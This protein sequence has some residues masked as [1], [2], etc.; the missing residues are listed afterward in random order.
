MTKVDVDLGKIGVVTEYRDKD[1]I[2]SIPGSSWDATSRMWHVPLSWASCKI[3]RGVFGDRLEIG[4]ELQV[5]AWNELNTRINPSLALRLQT[6]GPGDKR[7]LPFQRPGVDFLVVARHA[8]LADEMGTG[9]TIQTIMALHKLDQLGENPFPAC[10]IVPNAVKVNWQR[11]FAKWFPDVKTFVVGGSAAKRMAT[12]KEAG[13]AI[14]NG[15]KVVVILAWEI[16]WR[17]SRLAPYG[18]VRLSDP[19]RQPKELNRI[20]WRTVVADEAH[21]MKDP[22]A[23]QTRATWQIG[24]TESCQFRFALTGTPIANDPGDLW[25]LMHF[26]DPLEYPS[27]TKW[28]DRFCLLSWNAFGGMEV[29]GVR[30]DTREEF[31]SIVDPRMRRMP[32]E[33]VLP[34][35]PKK[36]RS[37][38]F[39]EMSSK[40]AKAYR[41]IEASMVAAVDSAPLEDEAEAVMQAL[42][43]WGAPQRQA[44]VI[45]S[46]PLVRNL[47][48]IQ[49]SSSY[50]TVKDDG[51]VELA[52]PSNKLD[53]LMDILDE[54]GDEP[55]VVAAESRQLIELAERRLL[56]AQARLQKDRKDP[57]AFTFRHIVGGMTDDERERHKD[58]FQEGRARVMLMTVKAGGVGITLTRAG[59]IV[60]LQRSWSMLD[61]KQ[62]EDRVHRIGSEIHDKI[63][64]ID[65][66]APGTV[67]EVQIARLHEKMER[68]EEIV[69]DKDTLKARAIQYD[70]SGQAKVVDD[71][72]WARVLELEAEA[73]RLEEDPLW[74]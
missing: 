27:K 74:K 40:Q 32:K 19:E 36:L 72:A 37:V 31:Y 1:L 63:L 48:L 2:R 24:H 10:L 68:L 3:L 65:I 47:R 18:S 58:D 50:A 9:K 62:S 26:V 5:W 46:N 14:H 4:P 60:F 23:K 45:A 70:E 28:V 33:L 56:D 17:H 73:A 20:M 57:R 7:L 66:V 29:I 53:E 25:S 69:R 55:V 13:L 22:K 12:F 67:E 34:F 21:K 49:F 59:V 38:R 16:T 8:L 35:L 44:L 6:D 39:A 54:L 51:E 30:P 61:N 52:E 15:E 71:A 42:E 11:E 43:R 41:E 64:V